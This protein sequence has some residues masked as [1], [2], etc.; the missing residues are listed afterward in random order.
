VCRYA[1]STDTRSNWCTF[2]TLGRTGISMY[3]DE[4]ETRDFDV[5]KCLTFGWR[6]VFDFG[7]R[8]GSCSRDLIGS[9]VC[10]QCRVSFV[11]SEY[12]IIII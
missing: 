1:Y 10:V 11:C 2:C 3:P 6:D 7:V 12:R 9:S 5:R 4:G 8:K